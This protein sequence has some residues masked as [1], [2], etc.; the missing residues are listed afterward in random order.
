MNL[1]NKL[2]RYYP[3]IAA[4]LTFSTVVV[5]LIVLP[6]LTLGALM[7]KLWPIATMYLIWTFIID[8]DTCDRGG[9]ALDWVRNSNFYQT[10]FNYFPVTTK[11]Q[12]DFELNSKKNYLF[13]CYPH[14]I[15]PIGLTC[16]MVSEIIG[17]KQL[18]PNHKTYLIMIKAN[19][20]IPLLRDLFLF[21]GSCSNSKKSMNWILGESR[22]GNIAGI[23]IGGSQEALYCKPG[24]HKI[25]LKNKKGF[26]K[27]AIM[28]G[29]PIVPVYCFGETDVFETIQFRKFSVLETIQSWLL[30]TTG[31][32]FLI[33][34]GR[35]V[36]GIPIPLIPDRKPLNV[37]VGK[38]IDVL[39]NVHPTQEDI[40][41]LHDKFIT[42]LRN[43]FEIEKY[44]YVLNP[45][46]TELI[47][48]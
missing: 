9:R 30:K 27:M 7:T 15:L 36:F 12:S 24:E 32:A 14:G 13:C 20:F 35:R 45:E 2:E 21:M 29:S 5:G 4:T 18:F 22:G 48:E 43:L 42:E 40:D 38:P 33:F 16:T 41:N 28:N 8:K 17:C 11:K 39:R 46:K 37:I 10:S 25:I 26:V 6:I 19:F 34:K 1:F 44:K 47:I 3:V 31:I 23:S